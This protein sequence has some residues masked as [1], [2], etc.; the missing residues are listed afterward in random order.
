MPAV[1][2]RPACLKLRKRHRPRARLEPQVL[3]P[4]E[5]PGVGREEL[6]HALVAVYAVEARGFVHP[7]RQARPAL[8]SGRRLCPTFQVAKEP[9]KHALLVQQPQP[10]PRA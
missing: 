6:R 10:P 7:T 3:D 4:A 8:R 9:N 1:A 2:L 5:E